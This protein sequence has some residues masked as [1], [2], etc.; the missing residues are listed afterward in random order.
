MAL[1]PISL[2][3]VT[4][5]FIF[6]LLAPALGLSLLVS[7]NARDDQVETQKKSALDIAQS[8]AATSSQI[9][10][11]TH[12]VLS[13]FS[14]VPAIVNG[15]WEE[16]SEFFGEVM[17]DPAYAA[18]TGFAVF[19]LTGDL[20][21]NSRPMAAIN[22]ADRLWFQ[23]TLRLGDFAN[24]GYQI[25]R[26]SGRPILP[27]SHPI[28]GA[29]GRPKAVLLGALNLDWLE[30]S[31]N[32]SH[33]GTGSTIRIL[34]ASGLILANAPTDGKWVGTS[35]KLPQDFHS[36]LAAS[37]GF[38]DTTDVDGRHKSF[39]YARMPE[40]GASVLVGVNGPSAVE[41]EKLFFITAALLAA[42]VGVGLCAAWL[43]ISFFLKPVGQ[44]V[45]AT[46]NLGQQSDL[47]VGDGI[48][49]LEF[50]ELA[51]AFNKM[52]LRV[53]EREQ[54][55]IDSRAE[56]ALLLESVGEGIVG[57]DADGRVTF[58]NQEYSRITGFPLDE[59]LGADMHSLLHHTR[60]DG[61]PYRK[62]AC[63]IYR[64]LQSGQVFKVPDD[65]FWTRDGHGIRVEYSVTPV[66]R[67][68]RVAGAVLILRDV[69]E[70]RHMEALRQDSEARFHLL[71]DNAG[72]A[73]FV[74]GPSGPFLEVN[75]VACL[76]L[77]YSRD[78]LLSMSPDQ[79]DAPEFALQVPERT[80]Q[81]VETGAV[82]F[83]TEHVCRDGRR[84]PTEIS[85]HIMRSGGDLTVISIARDITERK[86]REAGIKRL[87]HYDALTKLPN[88]A[89]TLD[90]LGVAI[91][92]AKRNHGD[93]CVFYMDLDR[94]K[95]VNDSLGH[96]AGD[97]LLQ[98]VAVRLTECLRESDTVGRI[99]GDEF[100]VIL[101]EVATRDAAE[102]VAGKIIERLSD[103][104]RLKLGDAAIGISIG[105]AF[106]T[107]NG[108]D[109]GDIISAADAALYE[110]KRRGRNRW[111]FADRP[112]L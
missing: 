101:P 47:R 15:R 84:I 92:Q 38:I 24:G 8:I 5:L 31:I 2:R 7:G 45:L 80:K 22:A 86:K 23:E 95:L 52:A 43:G 54:S 109:S 74:H 67:E 51:E 65:A 1:A 97:E 41:N 85:A 64:C 26:S 93:V 21:C 66:F 75:D 39:A 103:P 34:D 6:V 71:F 14:H 37:E 112:A 94:F 33:G 90:R 35:M 110:A 77:G 62:E 50:K 44:L 60:D 19:D 104:F 100:I 111:H 108:P 107:T 29:D 20:V 57:L 87:A 73:I 88:R 17:K 68:D 40:N 79:I 11:T 42:I 105:I 96:E 99:G 28:A 13:T 91:S 32:R 61:T 83:E 30:E 106:Y 10:R 72:D 46:R 58:A 78:E 76:R 4:V 25:G 98:R 18:Y 49:V 82:T 3:L 53:A 89:L 81:I 102:P 70:R 16:C 55:L 69:T 59:L 56:I 63:P 48:A 36:P 27:F 12:S 9:A